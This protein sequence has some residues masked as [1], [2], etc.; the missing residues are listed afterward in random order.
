MVPGLAE[1]LAARARSRSRSSMNIGGHLVDVSPLSTIGALCIAGSPGE[2]SRRLFN[3][4]LAWGLS[5]PS[6]GRCLLVVVLSRERSHGDEHENSQTKHGLRTSTQRR[7]SS[8]SFFRSLSSRPSCL[9]PCPCLRLLRALDTESG[10]R[11]AARFDSSGTSTA[12][13]ACLSPKVKPQA[14]QRA[15]S[16]RTR[17]PDARAE[18]MAWRRSSSTSPRFRPSSRARDDTERGWAVRSS[19]RALRNVTGI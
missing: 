14:R 11:T 15:G 10:P 16:I 6:S 7:C 1:Q 17:R 5:M 2:D 9:R 4:L 8:P 3:K 18:R 19:I 12:S 13:R